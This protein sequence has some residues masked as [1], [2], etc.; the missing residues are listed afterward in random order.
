[1]TAGRGH[2]DVLEALGRF[3]VD[4]APLDGFMERIAKTAV[5]L[6]DPV[7]EASI[8][9]MR[10]GERSWTVASTG[11]MA[12]QLDEAQYVLGHGPCIDAAAGG[13]PV[14]IRD[15]ER[16]DRWRDY[17]PIAV[18]AGV[19]SSLSM[20]FPLQQHVL[21]ALNLYSCERDGFSDDHLRIAHEIASAAAV[22]VANAVLYESAAQL[23]AELQHAM[24]SRAT[25]EQA[26]GIVMAQSGLD[27]D[28][29][30]DVLVRASQRENRKLRELASELV[31]RCSSPREERAG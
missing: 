5:E 27:P 28:A 4:E 2:G 16:D 31:E 30:F 9:F 12:T 21:A 15:L 1:V 18:E 10:G 8:T 6:I 11:G 7:A 19:Q 3:V 17:A 22:G 14:L 23:A 13:T 29:A 20:P 26:K 25:I 24:R